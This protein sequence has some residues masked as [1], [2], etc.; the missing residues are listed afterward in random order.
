MIKY[1]RY[2]FANFDKEGNQTSEAKIMDDVISF[3]NLL[4][5]GTAL[6]NSDFQ[7]MLDKNGEPSYAL[8]GVKNGDWEELSAVIGL[9][10]GTLSPN[11]PLAPYYL[12]VFNLAQTIAEGKAAPEDFMERTPDE[13]ER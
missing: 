10:Y 4:R 12:E 1:Y 3:S 13:P 11:S 2:V 7:L 8:L 6:E 5:P 9:S